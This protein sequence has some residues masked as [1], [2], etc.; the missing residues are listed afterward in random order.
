MDLTATMTIEIVTVH[1]A[2]PSLTLLPADMPADLPDYAEWPPPAGKR[3][4]YKFGETGYAVCSDCIT[5]PGQVDET[6]EYV[7]DEYP[8]TWEDERL[9]QVDPW[10]NGGWE[11]TSCERRGSSLR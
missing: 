9:A 11:C 3:V 1:A 6:R 4:I 5:D 10:D 8:G 7:R 2:M